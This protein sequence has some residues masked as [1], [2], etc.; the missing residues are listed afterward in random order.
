MSHSCNWHKNESCI[1]GLFNSKPQV[2]DC[3]TCELYSGKS[4]GLGDRIYKVAVKTG[5]EKVVKSIENHIKKPCGCKERRAL[6]NK[7]FP[8]KD[9]E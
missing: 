2:S 9:T 5:V 4:R 3:N 6:L 7:K 1:H 8:T